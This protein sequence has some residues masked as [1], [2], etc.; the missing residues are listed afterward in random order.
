MAQKWVIAEQ[1]FWKSS[2]WTENNVIVLNNKQCSSEIIKCNS[3][4]VGWETVAWV[5]KENDEEN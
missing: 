5:F 2:S 1:K 4:C 3:V